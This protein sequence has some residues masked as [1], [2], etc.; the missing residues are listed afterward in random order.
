[1][2]LIHR[3]SNAFVAVDLCS[4]KCRVLKIEIA[5]HPELAHDGLML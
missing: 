5:Q 3:Q 2:L 1:M 4:Q